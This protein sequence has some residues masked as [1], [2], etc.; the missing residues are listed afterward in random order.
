MV[1]NQMDWQ[2]NGEQNSRILLSYEKEQ[3]YK[4]QL[5]SVNRGKKIKKKKTFKKS[6][7][8]EVKTI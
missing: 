7:P 3:S 4:A 6:E 2:K 1:L 5:D 8:H